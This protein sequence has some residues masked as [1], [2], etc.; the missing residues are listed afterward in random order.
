MLGTDILAHTIFSS[1]DSIHVVGKESI[2]ICP[3]FREDLPIDH[4]VLTLKEKAR[5]LPPLS[6]VHNARKV[7]S[8]MLVRLIYKVLIICV[9]V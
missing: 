7:V 4:K 5:P 1:L 6:M 9:C 3:P 8:L 2:N